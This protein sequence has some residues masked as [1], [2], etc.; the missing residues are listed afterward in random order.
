[1]LIIGPYRNLASLG[2]AL[3]LLLF[4]GGL[5]GANSVAA[6]GGTPPPAL[7]THAEVDLNGNGK[8]E[9]ITFKV[10]PQTNK[11]IITVATSS[12]TGQYEIPEAPPKGF[13]IV[14]IDTK[15]K[16]RE[17]VV[18]CPGESDADTY[19]IFAYSANKLY[20]L[21]E[22]SRSVE[23]PGDGSVRAEDWNGFWVSHDNYVLDMPKHTLNKV[24][25]QFYYVGA[26]ATVKKPFPIYTAPDKQTTVTNVPPGSKVIILLCADPLAKT[27]K[28]YLL[29][30]GDN[31]VGWV[32]EEIIQDRLGGI[33]W[34]G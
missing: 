30:T 6:T 27:T 16:N 18:S 17:I 32:K 15:D 3:A 28:W 19:Y 2:V 1:M 8:P 26:S 11:F 29:K 5:G 25:Q 20:K 10:D 14:A 31:L 34:A 4:A 7:Q 23:F 12:L 13:S 33:P 9:K 24:H 22:L 21:G